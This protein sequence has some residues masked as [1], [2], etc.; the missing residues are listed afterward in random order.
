MSIVVQTENFSGPLALLLYLIRKEEMDIFNINI[1]HITKQYLEYL[2]AMKKLDLELAGDFIAMAATLIQIKSRMLLPQYE[3]EAEET[4]SQDPRKELVQKLLEYQ[5]YQ[6]GAQ[7]IYER[8]LLGRDVWGRGLKFHM[9]TAEGDEE[10]L[11][12]ENP[13]YGLIASFRR[14]MRSANRKIHKVTGAMQSISERILEMRDRIF[15][16]AK[17]T[18]FELL[19]PEKTVNQI[20]VTFLSLL[21]LSRM[22]FV[23]MFQS[24]NY[25]DI[26]IQ[27]K[28]DIDGDVVSRTESFERAQTQNSLDFAEHKEISAAQELADAEAD[29]EADAKADRLAEEARPKEITAEQL[30]AKLAASFDQIDEFGD[31]DDLASTDSLVQAATDEEIFAEEER[32]NGESQPDADAT[33]TETEV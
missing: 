6:E 22:G 27:G 28:S 11:L 33:E 3:G 18:F 2:K 30:E 8:P 19:S 5:K 32:L 1:H 12:E 26:H 17:T 24:E 15:A 25:A 9:T 4:E 7:K 21:E 16:G 13:L 31:E 20:L 10:L 14:A 29:A 23:T